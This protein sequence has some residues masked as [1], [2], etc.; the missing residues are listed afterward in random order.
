MGNA[1]AGAGTFGGV[2][3]ILLYALGI[4]LLL[5]VLLCLVYYAIQERLIFVRFRLPHGY[6]FR[7]PGAFEERFI[8]AADGATLHGL[9]FK[10]AEPRGVVIYFHGNTGSLRRWGRRAPTFTASGYDVLMPDYRGYGKSRGR[11]SEA[12]LLEDAALWY[13]HVRQH[14]P[15]DRI[16]LYGRSLGSGMA[17]PL[18]AAEHPRALILESPFASMRE[19]AMNYL[20]ILPYRLLL[21][22]PFQNDR[23]IRSVRCPVYIFHGQRDNVV[24]HASALRLYAAIPATVEREMITFPRAHHGNLVR[25]PRYHRK[26]RRILRDLDAKGRATFAPPTQAPPIE[27][28]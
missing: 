18:A 15:Q 26:L 16:V 14:W 22:Y 28:S 24:P 19:A 3:A 2:W 1:P 10:A 13:R 9:Y 8:H 6:R 21:R 11:L 12:A 20:P 4:L 25:Y 23:A 5:Y 27:R 17:V 7:F